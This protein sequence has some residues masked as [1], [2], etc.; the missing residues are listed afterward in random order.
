MR[1]MAADGPQPQCAECKTQPALILGV[2]L[3]RGDRVPLCG[4]CGRSLAEELLVALGLPPEEAV[5]T[6]YYADRGRV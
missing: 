4:P 3:A 1:S 6:G 2:R 5:L